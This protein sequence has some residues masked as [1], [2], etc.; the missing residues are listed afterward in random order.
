MDRGGIAVYRTYDFDVDIYVKQRESSYY[1][2]IPSL[3]STRL[4]IWYVRIHKLG[5]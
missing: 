5:T 1:K 4:P 3:Q 2:E